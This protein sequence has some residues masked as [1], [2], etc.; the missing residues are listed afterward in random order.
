[1][2]TGRPQKRIAQNIRV[3][4]ALVI[5]VCI[6]SILHCLLSD[7]RQSNRGLTRRNSAVP[8]SSFDSF[9]G[10]T[11]FSQVSDEHYSNW[12]LLLQERAE[13]QANQ[14]TFEQY[15]AKGCNLLYLLSVDTAAATERM[16]KMSPQSEIASSQSTFVSPGMLSQYGWTETRVP[17]DWA[18]LNIDAV[19]Q[20]PGSLAVAQTGG[21]NVNWQLKH[22]VRKRIDNIWYQVGF[23]RCF[24]HRPLSLTTERPTDG[25][26]DQIINVI[27]GLVIAY[28]TYSPQTEAGVN[29]DF[30]GPIIPLSKYSDVFFLEWAKQCGLTTPK[31]AIN[32]LKY[33][34]VVG[35]TNEISQ[36][37]ADFIV[38]RKQ[39]GRRVR[40]VPVRR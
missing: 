2:K 37:I 31:T 38:A 16:R 10:K 1:M 36:P 30:R 19:L 24:I 33:F 21:N 3:V 17:P 11:E 34:M 6:C 25:Q 14:Q 9:V 18:R 20:G 27:S 28:W 12:S 39:A 35:V 4:G 5:A 40:D 13:F 29:M 32:G 22:A 26:Y 8:S 23:L 15:A 7:T